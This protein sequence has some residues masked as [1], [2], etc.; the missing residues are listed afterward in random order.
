MTSHFLFFVI[1]ES[2]CESE[3]ALQSLPVTTC[4]LE[5]CQPRWR[6]RFLPHGV[7]SIWVRHTGHTG[8]WERQTSSR[9]K[10]P[11]YLSATGGGEGRHGAHLDGE[12]QLCWGV[13]GRR[14][15][16]PFRRVWDYRWSVPVEGRAYTEGCRQKQGAP[17]EQLQGVL[18][19]VSVHFVLSFL[20]VGE[21][22]ERFSPGNRINLKQ[23][24]RD[25]Q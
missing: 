24:S 4:P 18:V 21:Q 19:F 13:L 22:R 25:I 6:S 15:K 17:G 14:W 8:E 9:R 16:K 5:A 1:Q 10:A 3:F 11:V 20:L 2:H 7:L 12:A 23:I